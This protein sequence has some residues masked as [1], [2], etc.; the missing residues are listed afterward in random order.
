MKIKVQLFGV[1]GRKLPEF[2]SQDGVEIEIPDGATAGDLLEYMNVFE[3][4]GVAVAMD[5]RIL[6]YDDPVRDGACVRLIQAAHG[7]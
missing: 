7:G 4:W 3:G 1:L 5:S 6:K 2:D